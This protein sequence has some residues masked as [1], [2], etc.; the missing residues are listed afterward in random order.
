M[1]VPSIKTLDR[2]TRFPGTE[3]SSKK[4]RELCE[5]FDER[6]PMAGMHASYFLEECNLVL[7]QC[8]VESIPR[9]HNKKSPPIWYV[10]NGDAYDTTIMVVDGIISVGCWGDIVERGNYD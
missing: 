10:N 5:R 3:C 7:N 6:Q 8:G 9:G 2:V 4:L 1:A